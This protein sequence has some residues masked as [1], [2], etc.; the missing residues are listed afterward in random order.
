MHFNDLK[1]YVDA[2]YCTPLTL[3]ELSRIF[4]LSTN[5]CGYL[6]KRYT[7]S[8]FVQYVQGLRLERAKHL[9][10]TTALPVAQIAASV[11]YVDLSRFSR[12]FKSEVGLTP[13]QYRARARG[14][15]P[16]P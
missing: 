9:L 6:F 2:H 16:P 14:K 1:R 3:T 11:G 10:E 5:Y 15:A 7:G 4:Y 12:L 8:T 13:A